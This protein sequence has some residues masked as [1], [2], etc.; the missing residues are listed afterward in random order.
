MVSS[1][2]LVMITWYYSSARQ[3]KIYD[4]KQA[5]YSGNADARVG[6]GCLGSGPNN[7]E[8]V[9][10]TF[11]PFFI[12]FV[13]GLALFFISPLRKRTGHFLALGTAST[14]WD[15]RSYGRDP[16][17]GFSRPNKWIRNSIKFSLLPFGSQI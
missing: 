4:K 10:L 5:K 11:I 2:T 1:D 9:T 14:H 17:L 8:N 6:G 12:Y 3:R 16:R 7:P 13:L 15:S